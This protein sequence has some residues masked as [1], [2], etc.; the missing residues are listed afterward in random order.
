MAIIRRSRLT[1]GA[2]TPPNRGIVK[3][4]LVPPAADDDSDYADSIEEY[5]FS[6]PRPQQ[7]LKY[8]SLVRDW[9]LPY[10]QRPFEMFGV[11]LKLTPMYKHCVEGDDSVNVT[12]VLVQVAKHGPSAPMQKISG[13]RGTWHAAI[14]RF[15]KLN[16]K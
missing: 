7:R 5:V 9:V 6:L 2:T 15:A 11:K 13:P 14:K 16:V 12:G 8:V 10:Q 4:S 3:R 1:A